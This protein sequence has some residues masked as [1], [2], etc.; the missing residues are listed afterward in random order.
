[1]LNSDDRDPFTW[2]TIP[3]ILTDLNVPLEDWQE[4]ENTGQAPSGVLFP[5]GQVR[6]SQ[7]AYSRWLDSLPTHTPAQPTDPGAIRDAIR[8]ALKTAGARGLSHAELRELFSDHLTETAVNDGLEA[9]VKAGCCIPATIT[10][11]GHTIT[12]YHHWGPQ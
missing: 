7:L 3:Q 10:A 11:N 6:I 5:D 2:L 1:M 8:H 12:R 9:L 4:W